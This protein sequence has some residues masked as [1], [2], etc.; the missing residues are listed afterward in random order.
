MKILTN[1]IWSSTLTW[2]KLYC[3]VTISVII[4]G[5]LAAHIPAILGHPWSSCD[6]GGLGCVLTF[7]WFDVPMVLYNSFL[8]LY[9]LYSFTSRKA[10]FYLLYQLIGISFNLVFFLFECELLLRSFNQRAPLWEVITLFSLSG[11]LIGGALLGVL[12]SVKLLYYIIYKPSPFQNGTTL[13]ADGYYHPI[14]EEDIITLVK[15]ANKLGLQVRCRGAAHSVGQSIYTD[16][17]QGYSA[18][19]N[20]VSEQLPPEGPN[21]NIMLDQFKQLNWIDKENGIVEAE[22]GIH[23]GPVPFISSLEESFLWKIWNEGWALSDLGGITEQTISGFLMTG[24]AGGSL[25]YDLAENLDAFRIVDGEGNVEWV[26]RSHP[27]FYAMGTSLGLMGIITKV[28]F[29]LIP[30]YLIT[31]QEDTT[32]TKLPDCKIDLFGKGQGTKLSM[33]NFLKKNPY[34]RIIWWPQ[35]GVER[36]LTWTASRTA[37]KHGI[38]VNPYNEFSPSRFTTFLMELTVAILYS[39]VG[40]K[41]PLRTIWKVALDFNRFR[42]LVANRWQRKFGTFLA[43]LF[44][45]LLTFIIGLVL[46]LPVIFFSIFPFIPKFFLSPIIAIFQP[47]T[48]SKNPAQQFVDYYYRSLPMDNVTDDILLGTEFT[49]IWLPIQH[50]ENIMNLL[51]LHYEKNGFAA[52]GSYS[53]EIYAGYQSSFWMHPGYTNGSDEYKDGAVRVDLFWYTANAGYPNTQNGYFAQFW[54][55]F[56]EAGI[57]FRLHWGKYVPDFDFQ[58]WA[59]Y[60]Q[61]NLPKYNDFIALREKRDPKN[62]F[63]T[64]YWKLRLYGTL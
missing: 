19:P 63:L 14:A 23:L 8:A 46:I 20:K 52:T 56:K 21:I 13:A 30:R 32:L 17:G 1:S 12:V 62:I 50:T 2:V 29:K 5:I 28:R 58:E 9:G 11:L 36:I 34:T 22:A 35:K 7:H 59:T 38:P 6:E 26:D 18:V 3:Y 37:Y 49:E 25:T 40:N 57:P 64:D 10:G 48:T 44:A 47:L 31:G 61:S 27:H 42:K 53:N 39:I 41:N 51:K 33:E 45:F 54:K 24:S 16:Q 43:G 60:Y 15:R 55:L 4:L